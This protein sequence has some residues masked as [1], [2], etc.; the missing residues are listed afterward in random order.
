[1]HRPSPPHLPPPPLPPLPPPVV[2]E[3][4]DI[5]P[6]QRRNALY[7]VAATLIYA[8]CTVVVVQW[9]ADD[10]KT[11]W[12]EQVLIDDG[13]VWLG[14]WLLIAFVVLLF[15][16]G[17]VQFAITAAIFRYSTQRTTLMVFAWFSILSPP[18]GTFAGL[19]ALRHLRDIKT[20][21]EAPVERS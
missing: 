3:R 19:H 20:T 12:S 17:A 7:H 13:L 21:P 4:K 14:K 10:W 2:A 5:A 15:A 11:L 16:L 6:W 1:M 9:F 8:I 18:V